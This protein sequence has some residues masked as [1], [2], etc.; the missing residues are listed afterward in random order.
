MLAPLLQLFAAVPL[1]TLG[2]V[3]VAA[4][5]VRRRPGRL[6]HAWIVGFGALLVAADEVEELPLPDANPIPPG[7]EAIP[8]RHTMEVGLG[9][10]SFQTCAGP[11]TYGDVGAMYRYTTPISAQTNLTAAAGTYVAYS[12]E[13]SGG[14]RASVG[15]EHRWMGGSLGLM[16]GSLR[17]E[18]TL[19][20]P[21]MPTASLRLGPRDMIFAEAGILDES[22][23]PLPGPLMA[24]GAG[25]A[26]PKLGNSWEPLR[27]RAGVSGMGAYLSPSFPIGEFG[28]VEIVGAYGDPATWGVSGV[29][30]VH[31]AAE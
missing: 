24:L 31:V 4:W 13:A 25:V 9:G 1:A 22:P 7:G 29:L 26:F 3:M 15:L 27:I 19:E 11:R 20:S 16:A 6:R 23:A 30:R 17:R 10:G 14:L 8:A 5:L 18:D 21:V 2:L 28:N 12:D